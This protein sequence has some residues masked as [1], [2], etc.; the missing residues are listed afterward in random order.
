MDTKVSRGEFAETAMR[1]MCRNPKCRMRLPTPVSNEREAF[2]C[3]GCHTSFY[4]K[5]CLVCEEQMVRKTEHQRI[6]GKRK[7]NNALRAG[8][9]FGRYLSASNVVSPSKKPVNKGPEPALRTD[10][11][12]A[13]AIAA[14]RS[15]VYAPRWVIE[16]VFGLVPL[17]EAQS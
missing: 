2:C 8:S 16:A 5:R 1:H 14:N 12:V 6:C 13:W 15:H 11:G 17:V 10:R 9:G 3:R 4:R 7:C